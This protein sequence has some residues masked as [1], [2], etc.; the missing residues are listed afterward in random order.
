MANKKL[1]ILIFIAT[2]VVQATLIPAADDAPLQAS[3]SGPVDYVVGDD[4]GWAPGVDYQAWVDG[5][6]F[7]MGDKL[8]IYIFLLIYTYNTCCLL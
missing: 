2:I 1:G 4:K 7:Y 5:K 6:D 3:P 8:G